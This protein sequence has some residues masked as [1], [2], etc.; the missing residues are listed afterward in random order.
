[1]YMAGRLRTPSRPFR[2]WM[3]RASYEWPSPSGA[4][5]AFLGSRGS[6]G[7]AKLNASSWVGLNSFLLESHRDEPDGAELGRVRKAPVQRLHD[8]LA[9]HRQVSH[10]HGPLHFHEKLAV[11]DPHG[12]RA[13]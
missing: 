9:K 6:G 13:A 2:T 8:S 10:P 3:F 5:W 4:A 7:W 12:A 1:M 11:P